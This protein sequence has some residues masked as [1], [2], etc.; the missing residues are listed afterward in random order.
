MSDAVIELRDLTISVGKG[1]L[2]RELLAPTT[3]TI[4]GG[5]MTCILGPSGAGKSTLLRVFAALLPPSSGTAVVAGCDVSSLTSQ[6]R[7]RH[8]RERV[9]LIHQQYNLF[10]TLTA[11]ENAALAL[12]LRGVPT[13]QARAQTREWMERLGLSDIADQRPDTL[14]GGEQQ[15]VAIARALVGNSPVLLADEPTGALDTAS[16]GVVVD[17]ILHAA[18]AGVCCVV[19]THNES[20]AARADHILMLADGELS[21]WTAVS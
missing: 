14:S 21:D 20:V 6:D 9:A 5:T 10:D 18:D 15:R 8:R 17:A 11:L 13:K 4:P 12:E 1:R 19:V 7:L 2:S 3:L 16:A